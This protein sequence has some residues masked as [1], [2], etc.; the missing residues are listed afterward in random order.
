M[1]GFLTAANYADLGSSY[2]QNV[3]CS[4]FYRAQPNQ[5]RASARACRVVPESNFA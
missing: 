5:Y 3:Q 1:F 4:D 2:H